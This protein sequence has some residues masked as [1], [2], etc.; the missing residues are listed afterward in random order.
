[1]GSHHGGVEHLDKVRRLAHRR[2]RIE[3]GF[4]CSGSAQSP[5]PFPHAV[6]IPELRR[7]R[8]P[9]DVVS[10]E[11]VQSFEKLSVVLSFVAALRARRLK[12]LQN[13]CPVGICHLGQHGRPPLI[14][15]PMNHAIADS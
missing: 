14:R 8:T 5:E 2:Q 11:I 15:P 13:D 9:R 10:H 7:K 6:P 12:H 3:E 4:E 1:M